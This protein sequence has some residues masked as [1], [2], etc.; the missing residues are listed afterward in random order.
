MSACLPKEPE[1]KTER[2][3]VL[4]TIFGS[5][6]G[7]PSL[8]TDRL[9]FEF[10]L[11][12]S[13]TVRRGPRLPKRAGAAYDADERGLARRRVFARRSVAAVLSLV[14]RLASA[15]S[16][17]IPVLETFSLRQ[18]AKIVIDPTETA[19]RCRAYDRAGV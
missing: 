6:S 16:E 4:R 2:L 9:I 8:F 19:A 17:Y 18:P 14:G 15:G 5:V 1:G 10:E 7:R 13:L 11:H 3:T 12:D